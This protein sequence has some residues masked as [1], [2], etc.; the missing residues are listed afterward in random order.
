[1]LHM[2]SFV[3]LIVGGLNWLLVGIL[4]WGIEN[5]LGGAGSPVSRIIFILV[6]LSAIYMFATHKHSCKTCSVANTAPMGGGSTMEGG[7]M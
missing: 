4:G 1:M 6:G 5:F 2:A 7:N 3:L